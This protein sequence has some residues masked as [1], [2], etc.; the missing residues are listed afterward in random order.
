MSPP[1]LVRTIQRAGISDHEVGHLDVP[2]GANYRH[3]GRVG[4]VD[5]IAL[6]LA[7]ITVRHWAVSDAIRADIGYRLSRTNDV[8]PGDDP[9]RLGREIPAVRAKGRNHASSSSQIDQFAGAQADDV[10]LDGIEALRRG[11]PGR[12]DPIITATHPVAVE[13]HLADRWAVSRSDV[14]DSGIAPPGIL[15]PLVPAFQLVCWT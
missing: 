10:A 4:V 12:N 3:V 2:S 15:H 8:A 9:H 11:V 6:R 1:K 5:Q 13:Q 7:S 14:Y